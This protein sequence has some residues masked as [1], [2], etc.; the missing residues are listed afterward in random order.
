MSQ[1]VWKPVVGYEGTYEVSDLGRVRRI[2]ASQGTRPGVVLKPLATSHG[3]YLAVHLHQAPEPRKLVRIHRI[4]A[5]AFHGVSDLPLVRHL[6]GDPTNNIPSNLAH[7][8]ADEN[9]RDRVRHG[10]SSANNQ[11][12][13][14]THCKYGH[15]FTPE[16]T[17]VRIQPNGRPSRKCRTCERRVSREQ[18]ARRAERVRRNR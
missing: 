6:D 11:N 4:V 7:G 16:N 2:A 17:R 1:E 18:E 9:A 3:G 5:E 14:K 8:T 13:T 12:L 15:E 10:R